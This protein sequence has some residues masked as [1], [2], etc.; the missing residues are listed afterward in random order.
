MHM[1]SPRSDTVAEP[2]LAERWFA[3]LDQRSID[4][5]PPWTAHVLGVHQEGPVTW[6]QL[7]PASAPDEG[8]VLRLPPGATVDHA[9]AALAAYSPAGHRFPKVINVMSLC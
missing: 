7:A 9:L 6:V 8:L 2:T 3:A 4:G 5:V 1:A